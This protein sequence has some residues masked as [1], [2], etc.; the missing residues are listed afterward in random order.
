M[1]PIAPVL[2]SASVA[3][4]ALL[5]Y[6]IRYTGEDTAQELPAPRQ[7]NSSAVRIRIEAFVLKDGEKCVYCGQPP[8]PANK[9]NSTT[10]TSLT[11]T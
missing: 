4:A 3:A 1:H 2:L 6:A 9:S 8:H 7:T 5:Y 11:K 10:C